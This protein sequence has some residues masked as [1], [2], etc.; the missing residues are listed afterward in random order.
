MRNKFKD[1]F[2]ISNPPAW[3]KIGMRVSQNRNYDHPQMVGTVKKMMVHSAIVEN[4]QS[5]DLS[6][7]QMMEMNYC[8]VMPYNDMRRFEK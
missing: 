6:N 3:L 1:D 8:S 7:Y 5:K 4:I 2:E